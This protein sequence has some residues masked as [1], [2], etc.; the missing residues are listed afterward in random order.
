MASPT[1]TVSMNGTLTFQRYRDEILRP[2]V[3]PYAAAFGDEFILMDDNARLHCAR[4]VDNFLVDE[5]ILRMDWP[6]NPPDMNSI[7][8]VCT[9]REKSYR[10]LITPGSNSAVGELPST[11]VGENTSPQH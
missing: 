10:S 8:H 4:L 5:G 2:I 6:E 1:C 7:E 9:S 3:V 11:V